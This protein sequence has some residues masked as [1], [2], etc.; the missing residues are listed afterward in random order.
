MQAMGWELVTIDVEI[1]IEGKVTLV[2]SL[3]IPSELLQGD[4]A[5][6]FWLLDKVFFTSS[7]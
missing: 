6:V 3:R 7:S 2:V 4:F 1:T 5:G